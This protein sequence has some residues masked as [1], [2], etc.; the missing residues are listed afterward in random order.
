MPPDLNLIRFI[1]GTWAD[2]LEGAS[3]RS[4]HF[5]QIAVQKNPTIIF[6][7]MVKR[8]LEYLDLKY[9]FSEN[10]YHLHF[11]NSRPKAGCQRYWLG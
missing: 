3:Y 6:S 8:G 4:R 9:F 5:Y 10:K 2:L 7:D 11:K 1:I